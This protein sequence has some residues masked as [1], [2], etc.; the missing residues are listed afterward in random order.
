MFVK[1]VRKQLSQIMQ[2]I[3]KGQRWFDLAVIFGNFAFVNLTWLYFAYLALNIQPEVD[4]FDA[5]FFKP[6]WWSN[7]SGCQSDEKTIKILKKLKKFKNT[8]STGV[9]RFPV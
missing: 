7:R 6:D 1:E 4:V 2:K 3:A 5:M 8:G 9:Y